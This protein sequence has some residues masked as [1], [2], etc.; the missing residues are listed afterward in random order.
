MGIK[1]LLSNL[2]SIQRVKNV[3]SYSGKTVAIDGY[4]WLH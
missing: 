3:R 1:D 4:C 2:K